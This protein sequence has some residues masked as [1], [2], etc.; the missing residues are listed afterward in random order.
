M[1]AGAI[2]RLLDARLLTSIAILGGGGGGGGG[3]YTNGAAG[4]LLLSY[5]SSL[6]LLRPFRRS[7]NII[8]PCQVLLSSVRPAPRR[9]LLL[10]SSPR[11][12]CEPRHLII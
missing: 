9:R 8:L 3:G 12:T 5:S 1:S 11:T 4:C 7:E 10:L 2:G 6:L